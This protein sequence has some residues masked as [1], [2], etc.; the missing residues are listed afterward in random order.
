MVREPKVFLFDEPFSNLDA[1]LRVAMRAE[2]R[3]LHRDLGV[4]S[5]FVTHDQTEA[6][7]LADQLIVM[8]AGQVEQVGKPDRGLRPSRPAASS[9]TSSV[10][11]P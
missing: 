2:V 10:R 3:R 6:M 5:V 7:T 8:N 11:R 1:K 9:P 4:T